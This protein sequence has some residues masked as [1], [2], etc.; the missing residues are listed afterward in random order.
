MK[1]DIAQ[2]IIW[3]LM[4]WTNIMLTYV[5]VMQVRREKEEKKE[6]KERAS[7]NNGSPFGVIK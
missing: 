1:I 4:L 6:R 7:R 2:Y 3:A 5:V